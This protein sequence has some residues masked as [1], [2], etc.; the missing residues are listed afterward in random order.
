M[1]ELVHRS[2]PYP[3]LLVA[4]SGGRAGLSAVH[5]R[6]AQNEAGRTVLDGEVTAVG[7]GDTSDASLGPSFRTAL[8]LGRQPHG[9]LYALY[10]GWIDTLL[11]L[12]AARVTGV[13][14]MA[15]GR[16]QAAR[17]QVG[18]QE[19]SQLAAEVLRLRAAAAK[20][21]QVPRRV[22]LNLLVKKLEAALAAARA[23]L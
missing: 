11:A 3:L 15:G 5:I 10:Q 20:E 21:K 16:E 12:R 7:Y 1:V 2:V 4:E 13:F 23:K 9:T 18:L 6:R 22:E 17:R 8:A 14:N 19:Y